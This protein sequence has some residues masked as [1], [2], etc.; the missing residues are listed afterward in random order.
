V[1]P[2]DGC[3]VQAAGTLPPQLANLTALTTLNLQGNAFRG[4]LP[5]EWGAP[6]ALP[7]LQNL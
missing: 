3:P 5:P 1:L 6:G 4:S 2:C 7:E